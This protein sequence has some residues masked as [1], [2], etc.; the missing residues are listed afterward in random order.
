MMFWVGVAIP[1]LKD[2]VCATNHMVK[3]V[4]STRRQVNLP[5][6]RNVR[7]RCRLMSKLAAISGRLQT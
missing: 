6:Q 3:D 7:R 5:G 2:R 1:A 4:L